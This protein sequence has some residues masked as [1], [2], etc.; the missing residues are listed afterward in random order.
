MLEKWRKTLNEG[1][2]LNNLCNK[3]FNCVDQNLL[4]AKLNGY[5]YGFEKQSTDFI[6]A[7]GSEK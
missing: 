4:I 1:V 3:A 7:Y 6:Y 5:E 2:V